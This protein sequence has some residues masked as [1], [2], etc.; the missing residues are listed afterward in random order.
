ML[1]AA[2]RVAVSKENGKNRIALRRTAG[3]AG[4]SGDGRQE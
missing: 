4:P 3:L 1:S 2:T